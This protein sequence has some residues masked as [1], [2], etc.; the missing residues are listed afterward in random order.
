MDSKTAQ[1]K[2]LILEDDESLGA[3][4][5][6]VLL[7]DGHDVHLA[8]RPDEAF[9]ILA[10]MEQIDFVFA[11]CLLP[12][13]T[14]VDFV[15]KVHED[16]PQKRFK[17]ILMSGIYTD[18]S[19]VQEAVKEASAV[20]FLLKPF[21]MED[22]LK[23]VQ[24]PQEK[25]KEE[26][27]GRKLLYQI[28]ANPTVTSRQKRKLIESI[29]EVSGFD[30]PFIYSLLVETHSSGYLNIYGENGSVSGIS[31][32]NGSIVA[33]DIDDKSTF[34][35]EMLIQSGYAV[36][37]DVQ[38][39]LRDKNNR[40]IGSYM[41]SHNQLSPHAFDLVLMEQMNIRLARTIIDQK[42]RVSFATAEVEM[43][44]P[45]ID[46]ET[47]SF[48]LH[49]WIASKISVPWLRSLFV[50]WSGNVINKSPT[51][52]EDHSALE[53]S[54]VR[55]LPGITHKLAG[56]VTLSQLLD[57]KEYNEVAV[58]KALHYLL[59]KGLIVFSKKV[60]FV[61]P[62][63]QHK[64]LKKILMDLQ[65][66]NPYSVVDY[67]LSATNADS[68]QQALQDF[69]A[70]IGEP[71]KELTSE[72]FKSWT[73]VWKMAEEAVETSQDITK[74]T[75]F[76]EAAKR[77]EAEAKIKASSLLEEAKK[78]LQLNQYG[79]A[80][81]LLAQVTQLNPQI[82]QVHI[83][84]SW[85]RLGMMGSD[86]NPAT[87]KE[88]ELE[89]MQVPPEERYDSIFPFVMGLFQKAKGDL[90]GARK[91]FEKSVALDSSF[92]AARREISLLLTA[93][94]KQDVFNRDLKEVF[95]GLFKKKS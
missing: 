90:N 51:F 16:S 55:A 13:M 54:L 88:V 15:K 17:T 87:L 83:F 67:I 35:G 1:T 52:R 65:G 86:S 70:V 63:E 42:I 12:Q 44:S 74:V 29:E 36:P 78:S 10:N 71:P 79:K 19:F 3:A 72:V 30:L 20:A 46:P 93:T 23:L 68:A 84:M 37:D 94:K 39:A 14:G 47:L 2:I 43:S 21:D 32:C 40:K 31:F 49:D 26:V 77:S 27:S 92:I 48:Y 25:K 28:F 66:K 80:Q 69:K 53:S 22:A 64:V 76:R 6:E 56:Q 7:R 5:K 62:A 34:L 61:T 81:T 41:I 95:V 91:S 85:S 8:S 45:S 33:V 50:I 18:K 73:Q 57:F 9:E 60:A 4:L 59:T 24:K 11:D 89:L 82:H 58:Y 38:N 75:Q